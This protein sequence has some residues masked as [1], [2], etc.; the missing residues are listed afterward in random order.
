M[1]DEDEGGHNIEDTLLE[2]DVENLI[3][4]D[5][6][7]REEKEEESKREESEYKPTFADIS[8]T[9]Q[10]AGTRIG[11]TGEQSTYSKKEKA[12]LE[13]DDPTT[14]INKITNVL[15][16]RGGGDD[17]NKNNTKIGEIFEQ[18][19]QK[20]FSRPGYLNAL[21]MVL[22][23]D[24]LSQIKSTTSKSEFSN[25]IIST[26]KEGHVQPHN[27]LRYVRFLQQKED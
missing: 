21:L 8:R 27:L 25:I 10:L 12:H 4:E 2:I 5:D 13:K 1:S 17:P 20:D 6:R 11:Q 22:A 15:I 3:S 26:A 18:I 9:G 14:I 23:H 7:K 19:S 16:S 24:A